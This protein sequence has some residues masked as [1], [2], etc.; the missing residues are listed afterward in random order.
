MIKYLSLFSGIGGFEYGIQQSRYGKEATCIAYSEIDRWADSIYRRRFPTHKP[1]GDATLIRTSD[2]PSFDLLVAG[3]PCQA[4]SLAGLQKGFSDCRGTLFFEIARILK[5][6]RPK[7]FLLEN[8]RNLLGHNKGETFKTILGVL[9]DL[10]YYVEWEILNSKRFVPQN[11][12]R[13]YIKG[14]LG[15]EGGEEILSI[16]R[17]DEQVSSGL[18]IK[19]DGASLKINTATKKGYAEA[20]ANDGVNLGYPESKTRRGRVQPE[21]IGA[22]MCEG[23]WGTVTEDFQIRKLTPTECERL[24]GFPDNWT[25][26]GVDGEKISDAQR[27]KCLGNAVTTNVI[28]HIMN[29]WDLYV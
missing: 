15:R 2:L 7:Y 27:Y 10:G 19:K 16:R 17:Y 18:N 20:F 4:F 25:Q 6:C 21:S 28:T 1:L 9:S 24:Q 3:F 26:F 22:L 14:C 29:H 23:Q 12:E 11:R 5:D 8:V 13:I